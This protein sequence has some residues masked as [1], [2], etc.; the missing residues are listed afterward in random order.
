MGKYAVLIPLT[1]CYINKFNAFSHTRQTY[2]GYV[3]FSRLFYTE[4]VGFKIFAKIVET[5]KFV[6]FLDKFTYVGHL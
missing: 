5:K 6:L 4:H 1:Y 3:G 2:G